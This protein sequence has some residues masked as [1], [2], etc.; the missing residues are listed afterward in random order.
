M[1]S[2]AYLRYHRTIFKIPA[3]DLKELWISYPK[4]GIYINPR[5][6]NTQEPDAD[7][8]NVLNE[9]LALKRPLGSV[10]AYTVST[11]LAILSF[12]DFTDKYPHLFINEFEEFNTKGYSFVEWNYFN[13]REP[14]RGSLDDGR[15]WDTILIS[16]AMLES[17]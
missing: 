3:A 4:G 1:L 6:Y 10:G 9:I 8:V 11:L 14:Y 17:G 13:F 12:K 15:W 7:V 2:L 5:G 16:W